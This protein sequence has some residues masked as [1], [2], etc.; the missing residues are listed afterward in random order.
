[1]RDRYHMR[2]RMLH[3]ETCWKSYWVKTTEPRC[4]AEIYSDNT[5]LKAAGTNTWPKINRVSR[6]GRRAQGFPGPEAK[7]AKE[8]CRKGEALE[9]GAEAAEP[10]V[11][12]RA[13]KPSLASERGTGLLL[14]PL[15][16]WGPKAEL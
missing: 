15:L 2:C 8:T 10:P 1:M 9:R 11:W 12:G 3:L 16:S 5:G 4:R 7:G 6:P 13:L 14:A